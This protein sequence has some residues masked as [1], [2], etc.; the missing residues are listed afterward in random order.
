MDLD[1][2]A[3][4]IAAGVLTEQVRAKS[5]AALIGLAVVGVLAIFGAIALAGVVRLLLVIVVIGVVVAVGATWVLRTGAVAA[6]RTI[7]EPEDLADHR[8]TINA[9]IDQ[10]DLPTGPVSAMRFA[11]RLRRGGGAETDRLRTILTKVKAELEA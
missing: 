2:L 3:R 8:H 1:D 6:I 7:G 11:W 10:A 5:R 9:A 4:G